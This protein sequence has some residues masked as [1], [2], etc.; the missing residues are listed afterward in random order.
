[1]EGSGAAGRPRRRQ[2]RKVAYFSEDTLEAWNS[3]KRELSIKRCHHRDFT[4]DEFAVLLL[5]KLE[6]EVKS[7][8]NLEDSQQTGPNLK[9]IL[10]DHN[11]GNKPN[12][13]ANRVNDSAETNSKSL[14]SDEAVK[15]GM[16]KF[17]SIGSQNKAYSRLC[18][19]Y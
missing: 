4:S 6:D 18:A 17:R 9:Y 14:I 10:D 12:K 8:P 2:P 13:T 7:R 1:M 11:Y 3:K 19:P 16:Y 15:D 5:K